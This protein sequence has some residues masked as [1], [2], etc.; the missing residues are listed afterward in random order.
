MG[1]SYDMLTWSF[2]S[3]ISEYEFSEMGSQQRTDI[4]DG[5]MRRVHSWW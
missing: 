3:K 4:V 5:Y 2:L 1:L